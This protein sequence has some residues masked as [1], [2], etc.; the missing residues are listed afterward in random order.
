MK[1]IT[2]TAEEIRWLSY[3]MSAGACRSACVVYV[4]T[5]HRPR[6][7]DCANCRFTRAMWSIEEKVWGE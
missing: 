1:T 3:Q 7:M 2:L 4:E 6:N 5:G